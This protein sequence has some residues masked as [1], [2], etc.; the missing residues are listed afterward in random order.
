MSAAPYFKGELIQMYI[1]D[2]D[3]QTVTLP[4]NPNTFY[5]TGFP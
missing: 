2:F 1:Q 3:K 5:T 4:D